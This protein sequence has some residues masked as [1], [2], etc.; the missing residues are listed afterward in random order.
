M[1]KSTVE[2]QQKKKPLFGKRKEKFWREMIPMLNMIRK[3]GPEERKTLLKNG[4]EK[5]MHSIQECLY[6]AL[7]NLQATSEAQKLYMR[8]YLAK[9]DCDCARIVFCS[10]DNKHVRDKCVK[11]HSCL[12]VLFDIIIPNLEYH[13]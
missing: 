10:P 1:K 13:M 5:L 4:N 8:T 12:K 9:H 7:F 11:I 6:N 2:K 3:S